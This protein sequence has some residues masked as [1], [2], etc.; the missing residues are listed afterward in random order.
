MMGGVQIFGI[1]AII[2]DFAN[3]TRAMLSMFA[4][5]SEYQEMIHAIG[6][7]GK[8]EVNCL[9]ARLWSGEPDKSRFQCYKK[10][11]RPCAPVY[12]PCPIDENILPPATIMAHLHQHNDF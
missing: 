2:V 9:T 12:I 10:P 4:E 7:A 3:G 8:L 6:P 1:A 11:R 5:G